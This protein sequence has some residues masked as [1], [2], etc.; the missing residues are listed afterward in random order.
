ML[1]QHL[2]KSLVPH[3]SRASVSV[4]FV[5]THAFTRCIA[6]LAGLLKPEWSRLQCSIAGHMH[7]QHP[8]PHR[9][10]RQ[11][12]QR[13]HLVEPSTL[14]RSPAPPGQPASA[15]G[16]TGRAMPHHP[17]KRVGVKRARQWAVSTRKRVSKAAGGDRTQ[18]PLQ[19][20][21]RQLHASV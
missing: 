12:D 2:Q 9:R 21:G 10:L 4:C 6:L 13:Q 15:P 11:D 14:N 18:A 7:W 8:F 20:S 17:G 5:L 3:A 19:G 16:R 1:T